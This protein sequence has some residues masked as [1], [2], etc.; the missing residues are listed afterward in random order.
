MASLWK[1]NNTPHGRLNLLSGVFFI[2]V[3][4]GIKIGVEARTEEAKRN[5]D[6]LNKSIRNVEGTSNKTST[7]IVSMLKIVAL[8][9]VAGLGFSAIKRISS[10]YTN[11]GNRIANV[12]GRTREFATVQSKLL[13]VAE[14]TRSSYAGTVE[15]FTSFGRA[16]RNTGTSMQ[17]IVDVTKTVQQAIAVSGTSADSANKALIQLGQG[18]SSGALRGEELNSVMEQTPRIAR[19]IADELG[20]SLGKMRLLAAEGK[21]TSD[22]VFGALLKQAKKISEEFD[23][24]V[25]TLAQSSS[26][27]ASNLKLYTGELLKGLGL[28]DSLARKQLNL[29]K[30]I[31]LAAKNA[32]DLG[33]G[34]TVAYHKILSNVQSIIRPIFNSIK[35]LFLQFT[36]ILP[37]FFFT[38]TFKEDFTKALI[39]L[40]MNVLGGFIQWWKRFRFLTIFT[41]ESD[42]EKAIRKLRRLSPANWVGTGFNSATLKRLFSVKTLREFGLAFKDL[43]V[44][45]G[46]NSTTLGSILDKLSINVNFFFRSISRYFGFRVDTIFTF[47]RGT[48]EAFIA[49]LTQLVRGLSNTSKFVF[50]IG[51]IFR[52]Y[53]YPAIDG[54][55]EAIVDA[56]PRILSGFSKLVKG[57]FSILIDFFRALGIIVK[58]GFADSFNFDIQKAIKNTFQAIAKFGTELGKLFVSVFDDLGGSYWQRLIDRIK[59]T[60]A[61]LVS[62][63]GKNIKEFGKSVINVFK[64]IYERVIGN[65]YWTDTVENIVDTA[66]SLWGR[67]GKGIKS[68]KDNF[69]NTF[70]DIS[71]KGKFE[72]ELRE[73]DIGKRTVK[74]PMAKGTVVDSL[75]AG[76][77]KLKEIVTNLFLSFPEFMRV[78]LIGVGAILVALLFPSGIIKT[79]LIAALLTAMATSGTLIA[80][81]F[82][83]KL[84]GGSFVYELGYALGKAAG[85]LASRILRDL[86]KIANALFGLAA[87]FTRGFLE[88]LPI[89]GAAFKGLFTVGSGAGVAGPFGILMTFLFGKGIFHSLRFFGF[90]KK[91]IKGVSETFKSITRLLSGNVKGAGFVNRFLFGELGAT[92]AISGI[93]AVLDSFGAFDSLFAKSPL[94]HLIARGGLAYL[95]ITGDQGISKIKGLL[96]THILIPTVQTIKRITESLVSKGSLIG[97][98]IFGDERGSTFSAR[99]T[100]F[101]RGSLQGLGKKIVDIAAPLA[102]KGFDFLKL[103]L[104]GSNPEATIARF[105][106]SLIAIKNT[107]LLKIS[108]FLIYIKSKNITSKLAEAFSTFKTT[109]FPRVVL[110]DFKSSI[111]SATASIKS[112][113]GE[114]GLLGQLFY[115][116]AGRIA[117]IA[118]VLAL[119]ALFTS[120]A[121]AAGGDQDKRPKTPFEIMTRQIR[122]FAK[123]N[124]IKSVFLGILA[125]ITTAVIG[126]FSVILLR[127]VFFR[128]TFQ[129]TMLSM[130]AWSKIVFN[131]LALASKLIPAALGGLAGAGIASLFTDNTS[132]QLIVGFIVG[133]ITQ[134]IIKGL[135]VAM[136][137]A[138]YRGIASAISSLPGLIGRLFLGIFTVIFAKIVA[139]VVGIIAGVGILGAIGEWLFG[140][141]D[142]FFGA[143]KKTYKEIAKIFGLGP[144]PRA[145]TTGL[146]ADQEKFLKSVG[147]TTDFD[148]SEINTSKLSSREKRIFKERGEELDKLI[149]ES[150]DKKPIGDFDSESKAALEASIRRYKKFIEKTV[151]DTA[152]QPSNVAK[153]LA[154]INEISGSSRARSASRVIKQRA[155]D[156]QYN[157]AREAAARRVTYAVDEK[158]RK[159]A[160]DDLLEIESLRTTTFNASFNP[161]KGTDKSVVELFDKIKDLQDSTPKL[162]QDIS[163]AFN[164]YVRLRESIEESK[165]SN[166]LT[167][168]DGVATRKKLEPLV[169]ETYDKLSESV[170]LK[171]QFDV[172]SKAIRAFEND[173]KAVKIAFD[174]ANIAFDAD[175]FYAVD[176]QTFKRVQELAKLSNILATEKPGN[177][178]ERNRQFIDKKR[179]ET[180]LSDIQRISEESAN[181]T[182]ENIRNIFKELNSFEIP[183]DV[184]DSQTKKEQETYLKQLQAIRQT[185]EAKAFGPISDRFSFEP[186]LTRSTAFLNL[187]KV[188]TPLI[189]DLDAANNSSIKLAASITTLGGAA[190]LAA[191][192]GVDLGNAVVNVGAP[193]AI[194]AIKALRIATHDLS[195]AFPKDDAGGVKTAI[196]NIRA[197]NE[198]LNEIPAD[199]NEVIS[200][201]NNLGYS[202]TTTGFSLFTNDDVQRLKQAALTIKNA[203]RNLK[204][205]SS[206]F[207][208]NSIKAYNAELNKAREIL[209]GLLLKSLRADPLES[210]KTQGFDNYLDILRITKAERDKF[211]AADAELKTLEIEVKRNPERF[212]D[213]IEGLAKAKLHVD[214]LKASIS[215]RS[216]DDQFK[217]LNDILELNLSQFDF[218]RLDSTTR[219]NLDNYARF[220]EGKLKSI[221][222]TAGT[223]WRGSAEDFYEEYN[224]VLRRLSVSDSFVKVA[225]SLRDAL[226]GGVKESFD[227]ISDLLGDL[228]IELKSFLKLT[229]EKQLKIEADAKQLDLLKQ[230][231]LNRDAPAGVVDEIARLSDPRVAI[232][233]VFENVRNLFKGQVDSLLES[234]KSPTEQLSFTIID[235]IAATKELTQAILGK[236]I[237]SGSNGILPGVSELPKFVVTGTKDNVS[238]DPNVVGRAEAFAAAVDRLSNLGKDFGRN[239]ITIYE[240]INFLVTRADLDISPSQ[241]IQASAETLSIFEVKADLLANYKKALDD[242]IDKGSVI[243]VQAAK[244]TYDK[245][246]T[247]MEN[248]IA[249]RMKDFSDKLKTVSEAFSS[250]LRTNVKDSLKG[251]LKGESFSDIG[252][253]FLDKFTNNVI[254][255]FVEG[256]TDRTIGEGSNFDETSKKLGAGIYGLARPTATGT[257][258]ISQILSGQVFPT[259]ATGAT[260]PFFPPGSTPIVPTVQTTTAA[261][262]AAL[263][264]AVNKV[265]GAVITD[266]TTTG[267]FFE[268]LSGTFKGLFSSLGNAFKNLFGGGGSGGG[269]DLSGLFAGL[270]GKFIGGLFS[271]GGQVKGV[272]T[273]LSDSIPTM[274]SNG[275]FVVN[276]KSTKDNFRLLTAI[277]NNRI[278]QYATG[279]LVASGASPAV[280]Q[281]F[282]KFSGRKSDQMFNIYITGDISRQT[283]TEIRKLI[284]TLAEGINTHNKEIGFKG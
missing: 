264:V 135:P 15:I 10:E 256:L 236:T 149:E 244:A 17:R 28:S 1:I 49:T 25:P 87:S 83:A 47:K 48:A 163:E 165:E 3:P 201:L 186:T 11:L 252:K 103:I 235:S 273:G 110:P 205:V 214:D 249:L 173:V 245:A 212:D 74:V 162:E 269:F 255:T 266:T 219:S 119:L 22:L 279:G 34:I 189:Q 155:F 158:E 9:T 69:I 129:Q 207:D 65:S 19:A 267:G 75:I 106:A 18:L 118:G 42:I 128:V 147:V 109:L 187:G 40:D 154:E 124:P 271:E 23:V 153:D 199:I 192:L 70:K 217:R 125:G 216:F 272:G 98:L 228:G 145:A 33:A 102:S 91:E 221:G 63:V 157:I 278:R 88:Q 107:A 72:V 180:E 27:I 209:N 274:L 223:T 141:S 7:A 94:A 178:E 59:S 191:D 51:K 2:E 142:T 92:R 140:D 136:K 184:I 242:A 116:K 260:P 220:V 179:I 95:L 24:L 12:T 234:F 257:S 137:A 258:G 132:T 79:Y 60:S 151:A 203:E 190:E 99:L 61:D 175:A 276:A 26:L 229:P 195:V 108:D 200:S 226:V 43:A 259:G 161:L 166:V 167:F 112:A 239:L 210:L 56:A 238:I 104:L 66:N 16:L 67:A 213:L 176:T 111:A 89:I 230:I 164:V 4:M 174:A 196:L 263:I 78:A 275:E 35:G 130:V 247:E 250:D 170:K 177:V 120:K 277:N 64:D 146:K 181:S 241:I 152:F 93:A 6:N 270:L 85:N 73:I 71:K 240:R 208:V 134:A 5:I 168:Y 77:I 114:S 122:E 159:K 90:F 253:A 202:F 281:D 248:F 76:V 268:T 254:D 148:I 105:K 46:K 183:L 20:L 101:V 182:V 243:Q 284:P 62:S 144:K 44:A 21:L 97:K 58:E 8:I 14:E 280:S 30:N 156:I 84:T 261:N 193:R 215:S 45:I 37:K 227:T 117:L 55:R 233:E 53:F 197:L 232:S 225:N 127:L 171:L 283:K 204:R 113:A 169:R 38:N 206:R 133:A 246:L 82:G 138:L 36:Q 218:A 100:D 50:Q 262:D 115:G 222:E 211:F 185:K 126:G 160:K 224:T 80:E 68:F 131:T 172:E 139:I 96:T 194:A 143:L 231:S 54:L 265:E 121:S 29:A 41:W 282:S 31:G 86:P 52:S 32:Y 237:Q 150:R 251:L 39:F 57:V 81:T 123:E 13:K 188:L 198:E